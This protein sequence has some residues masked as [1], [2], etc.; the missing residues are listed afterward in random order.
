MAGD[1]ARVERRP[2]RAVAVAC[3]VSPA[4][5]VAAVTTMAAAASSAD[6]GPRPP[7]GHRVVLHLAADP[8]GARHPNNNSCKVE[9]DESNR[10]TAARPAIWEREKVERER[11]AEREGHV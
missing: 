2:P 8:C 9:G 3:A 4:V 6:D 10:W 7:S 5:A 1:R 11:E